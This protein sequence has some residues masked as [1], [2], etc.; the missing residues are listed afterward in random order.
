MINFLKRLFGLSTLLPE[1]NPV[2]QVQTEITEYPKTIL[3]DEFNSS[4]W[5]AQ[6]DVNARFFKYCFDTV[7]TV[8]TSDENIENPHEAMETAIIHALNSANLNWQALI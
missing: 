6:M 8:E 1:K 2:S 3:L 7:D 5:Q 4:P